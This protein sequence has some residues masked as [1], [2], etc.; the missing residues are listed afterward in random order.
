MKVISKISLKKVW[1]TS[2]IK[3]NSWVVDPKNIAEFSATLETTLASDNLRQELGCQGRILSE[4]VE[5]FN[6]YINDMLKLYKNVLGQ[7]ERC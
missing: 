5:R 7:R 2:I 3:I 4:K 1:Y 6:D